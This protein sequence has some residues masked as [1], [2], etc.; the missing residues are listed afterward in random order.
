MHAFDMIT[1]FILW[2]ILLSRQ[3]VGGGGAEERN[4]QYHN[5]FEKIKS[6]FMSFVDIRMYSRPYVE[7]LLS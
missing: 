1:S 5:I 6:V 2:W 4:G 7:E 3:T